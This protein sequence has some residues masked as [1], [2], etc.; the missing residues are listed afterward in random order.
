MK[1]SLFVITYSLLSLTAV[2]AGNSQFENLLERNENYKGMVEKFDSHV[3]TGQ[4]AEGFSKF[5]QALDKYIADK[6]A[7]VTGES[8]LLSTALIDESE[9]Q[10]CDTHL[11][12]SKDVS[13]IIAKLKKGDDVTTNNQIG[14][15]LNNLN[16]MYYVIRWETADGKIQCGKFGN[17]DATTKKYE[18]DYKFMREELVGLPNVENIQYM[19]ADGQEV[20][21]LYR[22]SGSQR[23]TLVEVRMLPD[24]TAKIRYFAY[25]PSA[26]ELKLERIANDRSTVELLR[27]IKPKAKGEPEGTY[28]DIVPSV[29]FRDGA[30][31]TDV[32]VLKAKT[33]TS[34]T[35][36]LNFETKTKFSYNEQ[37][38]ELSL[39]N[40]KGSDWVKVNATNYTAGTKQIV[41]VVPMSV[42]IDADSKLKVDAS[43]KNETVIP[44]TDK[45][46]GKI[47]NAQTYN[48]ALTD[49]SNKY[50][51]LE[52]YQRP[53]DKYSKVSVGSEFNN[54]VI[55][56]VTTK[57][58]TD[59]DGAKA[60]SVGKK[61]DF[62]DYGKLTTSFGSATTSAGE[63][64]RFMDLQHEVAIGK[65]SSLAITAR[66]SDDRTY[67]TMLQFKSRF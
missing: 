40:D 46:D 17:I 39:K 47:S 58:S 30:V 10:T 24:G 56:T 7:G 5:N 62:G 20:V 32:E 26:S 3:S 67:T 15:E 66:A 16:F 25:K 33:Q 8:E 51:D 37:S 2:H 19:P 44:A 52:L 38:T 53:I 34:L 61:T 43:V 48:M 4:T 65:S 29:K 6:E 22:G 42:D 49:H 18:G 23:N 59:T 36:N 50:V 28:V 55:G 57:F 31:P 60:Y 63:R 1:L 13:K 21:Y 35:E 14:L 45:T 9:C 11:N 54:D 12:L 64:N 41:T 27:K